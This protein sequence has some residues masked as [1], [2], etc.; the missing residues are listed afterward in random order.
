MFKNNNIEEFVLVLINVMG[1]L[2]MLSKDNAFCMLAG[3]QTVSMG[4]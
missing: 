3:C 4:S 2:E 1:T